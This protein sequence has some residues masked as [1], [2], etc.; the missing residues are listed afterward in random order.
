MK[1]KITE[2]QIRYIAQVYPSAQGN[3][4]QMCVGFWKESARQRGYEWPAWLDAIIE[5]YKPESIV[6]K[7]RDVFPP[8]D[9]QLEKEEEYRDEFRPQHC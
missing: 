2:E 1:P 7:R 9:E 8:T 4:T 5:K 6:R 3:N